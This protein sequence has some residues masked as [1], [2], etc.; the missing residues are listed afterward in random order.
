MKTKSL[1][2]SEI[3]NVLHEWIQDCSTSDNYEICEQIYSDLL[4]MFE[5]AIKMKQGG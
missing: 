2:E 5:H 3:D 4:Q 1:T